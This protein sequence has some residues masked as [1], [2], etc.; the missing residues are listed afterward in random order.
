VEIP[1]EAEAD[2]L[3]AE[4]MERME[5]EES[6]NRDIYRRRCIDEAVATGRWEFDHHRR[7]RDY[8]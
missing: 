2:A 1:A 6:M 3:L 8:G 4:V 7:R 5:R